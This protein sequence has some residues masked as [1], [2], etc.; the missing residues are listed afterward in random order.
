LIKSVGNDSVSLN[1]GLLN[2]LLDDFFDKKLQFT[3]ED[4][5]A[6]ERVVKQASVALDFALVNADCS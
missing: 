1:L 3:L 4:I 5:L 2:N 6:E